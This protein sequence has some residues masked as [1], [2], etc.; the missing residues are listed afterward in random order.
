[1]TKKSEENKEVKIE[2]VVKE[3]KTLVEKEGLRISFNIDF[4][5]YKQLPDEV[6]LSLSVLSKHGMTINF[7]LVDKDSQ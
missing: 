1:M 4:P 6:K 3:I 7:Q 2:R 5:T